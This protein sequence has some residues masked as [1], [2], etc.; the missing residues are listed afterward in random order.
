MSSYKYET[1]THTSEVSVCSILPAAELV[2]YFKGLGYTGI[3]V[4]DHFLVQETPE[5]KTRSWPERIDFFCH[6]YEAAKQEGEKV[7]LDVF[8]GWEYAY[9]WAHFLTYGLDKQW[10][11]A[12]PDLPDWEV[13]DYFD[14][15]REAGGFVVHAH[16]FRERV[17][18]VQ[19][20]PRH[21]DAVEV[22]NAGRPDDANRYARDYANSFGLF[23]TAGSDVHSTARKKLYGMRFSRRLKDEQ[24]F[25]A[26]V[27]ADEGAIFSEM[28]S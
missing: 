28:T 23:K 14:R 13:L 4:T 19:L 22:F 7:G 20:A 9:G 2:H 10:L 6:G 12:H 5:M 15:V 8:F 25:I 3:F 16:P 18:L 26:A 17:D 21:T 11:L 27:R 1:H 24:D